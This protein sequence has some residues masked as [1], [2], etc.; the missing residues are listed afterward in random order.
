M[1]RAYRSELRAEQAERTRER[2]L[3]ALVEQL[4]EGLEDFS[5]PRVAE[6]A[7]VSVRTVYHHFPNRDAQIE[8]VARLLDARITGG[9]PPP[10]ALADV[11][12]MAERIIRRAVDN[13]R[14]VRAQ[15]VPGVAR[16]VRERR[17][18]ERE[19]AIAR[20][21]AARCDAASAELVSAA[22]VTLISAQIGIMLADRCGLGGESLIATHAWIV[23]VVVDAVMRGD[24]PRVEAAHR[25]R[26]K[27]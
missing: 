7:G 4:G 10:R 14:E 5:I 25:A 23:R 12:D 20:A 18:R 19:A 21:V 27:R 17:R 8:A 22:L 24:V 26:S 1:T 2:I 13:M 16:L 6:R 9:E 3:E 15:L 11:P